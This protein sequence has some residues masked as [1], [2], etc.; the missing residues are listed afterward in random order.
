MFVVNRNNLKELKLQRFNWHQYLN[1]V[2]VF[3]GAI[4]DFGVEKSNKKHARI[5]RTILLK[6]CFE[7]VSKSIVDHVWISVPKIPVDFSMGMTVIFKAKVVS[8]HK[9]LTLC[10]ISGLKIS[11][12]SR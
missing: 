12:I 4:A 11:K 3:E 10:N 6:P 5:D 8:Y 7:F 2:R 9:G 1:Q